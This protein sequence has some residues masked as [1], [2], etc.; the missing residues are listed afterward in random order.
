VLV[1]SLLYVPTVAI[2][3]AAYLVGPGFAIGAGTS[4]TAAG[5]Q[6]GPLPGVPLLAGLP[7]GPVSGV[8]TVLFLLPIAAG[9]LA[10]VALARSTPSGQ[11]LP[12][13]LGTVALVGPVAGLL[14]GLAAFAAGGPLGGGRLAVVG[15]SVW[16]VALACAGG[17]TVAAVVGAAIHRGLR[18]AAERR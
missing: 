2:W 18:V 4:V 1:L 12:R 16:Q 7:E 9:V 10:G 11:P 15:P 14:V 8:A 3:A 13:L 17:I 6:L 5:V